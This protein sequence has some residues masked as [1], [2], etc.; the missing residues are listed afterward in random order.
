MFGNQTGKNRVLSVPQ[1]DLSVHADRKMV[2]LYVYLRNFTKKAQFYRADTQIKNFRTK[3]LRWFSFV[4]E[5]KSFTH[6]PMCICISVYFLKKSQPEGS[7]Y[8]N[9]AVLCVKALYSPSCCRRVLTP[10]QSH[11]LLYTRIPRNWQKIR[12]FGVLFPIPQLALA[13]NH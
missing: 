6:R 9:S 7:F 12:Q 1:I 13:G 5:E 2:I 4:C 10:L 11:T 8:V 3:I